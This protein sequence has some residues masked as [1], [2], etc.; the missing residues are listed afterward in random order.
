M[1]DEEYLS[2]DDIAKQLGISRHTVAKLSWVKEH[3]TKRVG[4]NKLIAD[5]EISE[6]LSRQ[7]GKRV[8]WIKTSSTEI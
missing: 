2:I 4:V 6:M 7:K 1:P 3:R 5:R 8:V